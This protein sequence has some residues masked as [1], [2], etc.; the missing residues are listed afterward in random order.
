MHFRNC[1]KT[2]LDVVKLHQSH[3]LLVIAKDLN[4]LNRAEFL[5]KVLEIILTAGLAAQG[6]DMYGVAWR[7][8]G[9]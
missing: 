1:S 4:C 6:R 7:V 2:V 3:V 8:D 9:Y 5:K